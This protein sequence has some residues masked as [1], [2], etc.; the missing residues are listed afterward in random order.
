MRWVLAKICSRWI[1]HCLSSAQKHNRV[2]CS[3]ILSSKYEYSDPR[4]LSEII[5]GVE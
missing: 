5:T 3:I 1:P 2:N 4:R